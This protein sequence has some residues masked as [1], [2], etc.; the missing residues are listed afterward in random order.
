[1]SKL[2]LTV[3][4]PCYLISLVLGVVILIYSKEFLLPMV[5]AALLSL[6]LYPLFKKL[7][8]WKFPTILAVFLTMLVVVI[9]VVGTAM[10]ISKEIGLVVSDI[11]NSGGKINEKIVALHNFIAV[12]FH[13]DDAT[14]TTWLSSLKDKLLGAS[15]NVASGALSTTGSFMSSLALIIVYVFCF[16]LYNRSFHDFAYALMGDERQSE[17]STIIGHIQKLVQHYLLGL[18]TVIFIIGTLNSIGL[19]IIGVDHALFFAFFAAM[20]TVIPYIGIFIGAS[21]PV[22]YVLLTRDSMWPAAGVLGIFLTVQFLESNFITPKIVGSRVSVNPFVAIVAL[23]IGGE[24]WGIPGMLLSIP[25]TAILKLLLDTRPKTKAI[26]YFLGSE[27]TDTKNDPFKF[28][29]KK[30]A[31]P[32][33]PPA[34]K[35]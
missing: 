19:F 3:K 17:T 18:L 6:L 16:L 29:G 28:F 23:L 10:I 22:M 1:M 25:M 11:V 24:I 21:L 27:L 35:K 34:K 4:I 9:V 13:V 26:G 2:P 31:E 8:Q 12:H 30:K 32:P 20:L 33:P 15:G 5:L 7:T 14:I